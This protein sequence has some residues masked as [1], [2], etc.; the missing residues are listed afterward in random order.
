LPASDKIDGA[1]HGDPAQPIQDVLVRGKRAKLGVEFD[2]YILGGFFG[3][4]AVAQDA[5]GDA[6][7]HGLVFQHQSTEALI[8]VFYAVC[9]V[10]T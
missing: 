4:G 3:R 9:Q 5:K 8:V 6:E 10:A 2:K 1:M 7:D